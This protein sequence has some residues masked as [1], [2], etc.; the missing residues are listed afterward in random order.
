[1]QLLRIQR[2][3]YGF[4]CVTKEDLKFLNRNLPACLHEVTSSLHMLR[5]ARWAL[6][7]IKYFSHRHKITPF[8]IG[9]VGD[10]LL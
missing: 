4:Y 3:F 9:V 1:M 7:I 8:G 6:Q 5:V 2:C 10:I